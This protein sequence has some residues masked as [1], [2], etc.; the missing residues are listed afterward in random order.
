MADRKVGFYGHVRQYHSLKPEIDKAISDVLESG[1]YVMGP[2]GKEFEKELAAYSGTRD[3]VGV[4]SGTDAL[5]LAFK[6]LGLGPGDEIITVANTFFA[7]AEAIWLIGATVVL[8]DHDPVTY[9]IDPSKIEAA[10]T[11]RTRAIVPVH[12][13]GQPA[14]MRA[15]AK[16]AKAHKLLVIEDNAQ[17]IG[18]RG[19]DFAIGELCDAVCLSFIIQKNLGCFG[20]GGAVATNRQEVADRIRILRNHGSPKRS[21]HSLGYNSRLDDLHAAVLRIKLRQID[22]WNDRRRSIAAQYGKALADV[23]L[24]LPTAKP[25]YRHVY[26]LYV[27]ESDDRDGLQAYLKSRGIIAQTHYPIAIHQQEGYPWGCKAVV[28]APLPNTEAGVPRVLSLP[29]YPELTQDEVQYVIDAIKSWPG[30]G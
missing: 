30:K 27:V 7:T 5:A 11:P 1:A 9:N 18:A 24:K 16:I 19:D 26:H 17:S 20:D 4:N 6:A 15:V 25:G 29:M 3:A 22:K 2:Q 21:H 12:L 10:I 8:V 13:Y 28:P 14:E 23:N